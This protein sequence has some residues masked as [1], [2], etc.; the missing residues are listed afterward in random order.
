MNR[1]LHLGIACTFSLPGKTLQNLEQIGGFARQAAAD[2]VDL[3]LTPEL[4]AC[5][6]GAYPDVLATAEIAGEG[7]ISEALLSLAAETN[8]VIAAGFAEQDE[9]LD[10]IYIAHL[11]AYPDGSFVTQRKQNVKPGEAPFH[12]FRL[13]PHLKPFQVR[14]VTCGL[15]ICADSG[16]ARRREMLREAK[17]DIFLLPSGAGG[18]RENRVSDE[19][20]RTPEGRKDYERILKTVFW[21]GDFV[22][23]SLE[24]GRCTALVNLTGFDGRTYY[25]CGHGCII[26]AMGEVV[27]FFPGQPNLDRQRPA[28]A[29]AR[30]S[31]EPKPMD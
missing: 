6:Y 3:L 4:S 12:S 1:H 27:A 25:H 15:L 30:L 8:V 28:Y 23:E 29:H 16:L 5:G 20:L 17:A 31:F 13:E 19:A 18:I 11:I 26:D 2:G 7:P 21:P 9:H 10:A 14:D 24:E 22:M